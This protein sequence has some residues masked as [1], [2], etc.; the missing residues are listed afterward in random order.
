MEYYQNLTTGVH[1]INEERMLKKRYRANYLIKY[2]KY[3]CLGEE[4]Y[5]Q[6]EKVMVP[7]SRLRVKK[8]VQVRPHAI[9]S[10]Q[11]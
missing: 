6:M 11:S 4:L 2:D 8:K 5:L 3:K 1:Q 7:V 10:K 9:N